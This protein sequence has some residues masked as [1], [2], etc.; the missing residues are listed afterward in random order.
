MSIWRWAEFIDPVPP[1][2]RLTLGEGSTP[3][4]H[5]RRIGPSAGLKHLYFKLETT[6]PTGTFK[7]RYA[8]VAVSLMVA[9]G[10][11]LCVASSSG[12]TGAALAAYCAAA[13]IRCSIAI[14]E[15]APEGKLKQM[16]AY[17]ARLFRVK[18]FG[19][20]SVRTA[21]TLEV[22]ESLGRRPDA[23]FEISAFRYNPAGMSG[24][25]SISHELA[26][27]CPRPIDHVFCMAGGGGL[28]MGVAQGVLQLQAA[29]RLSKTPAVELVQ[30]VGNDTI[31]TPL[32]TGMDCAR[33][34]EC[35][36][37][38]SGLQV[39]SVTDGHLAIPPIRQTGG[40][41]HL[42]TDEQVWA[43]QRRLAREEG[44]FSEPA[45]A[46]ALPAILHAAE[47]GR[48]SRDATIVCMISGSAFKDPP[49]MDRMIEGSEA[50][51]I[52]LSE[53]ERRILE[54]ER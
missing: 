21:E 39:A 33:D 47:A 32:A 14:V 29:G 30:P 22:L 52:W 46:T 31:A 48:I 7:D 1:E 44:I 43:A 17:G 9:R 15:T 49:S 12:N 38:I 45:G 34:I 5:S 26:E 11:K 4:L 16:L 27:Q 54:G 35:T 28:A 42:V 20:S 37:K 24:I 19:L 3:L 36:T 23:A 50:P 51:I 41:G 18:D 25:R 53:L 13:G 8:A 2:A 10:K 6:N 40:S